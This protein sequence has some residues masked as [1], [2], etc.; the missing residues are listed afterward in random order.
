MHLLDELITRGH[1]QLSIGGEWRPASDGAEI[2]VLDPSTA[3]A[4][5]RVS[6]GSEEDA[7]AAV[8]AAALAAPA[9]ARS[10]PR[11]RSEILRGAFERMVARS[12]AFG[13]LIVL[14]MGK[15]LAEARAE[16]IYA[17]ESLNW[18]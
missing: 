8:D 2:E 15:A 10:A 5:T 11:E 14:E 12:D 4:L 1:T 3:E 9:W 18:K 7:R 16:A 17:A 13:E 6:S